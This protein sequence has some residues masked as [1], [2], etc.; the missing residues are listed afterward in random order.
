MNPVHWMEASWQ[1][2]SGLRTTICWIGSE[3]PCLCRKGMKLFPHNFNF[4]FVLECVLT[5]QVPNLQVVRHPL[6]KLDTMPLR[7][8][9][10]YF[11]KV[12]LIFFSVMVSLFSCVCLRT[13]LLHGETK[14]WKPYV[15]LETLKD[16]KINWNDIAPWRVLGCVHLLGNVQLVHPA[17]HVP[18]LTTWILS[19]RT[20]NN[21]QRGATKI[22]LLKASKDGIMHCSNA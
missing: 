3:V 12:F 2:S 7:K 6:A 16:S 5:T 15:I 10:P 22:Q 8:T 17:C 11:I 21:S 14:V 13:G 1:R 19:S 20:C 18:E 9:V 4:G